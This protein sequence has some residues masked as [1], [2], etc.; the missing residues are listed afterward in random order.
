MI[1][2]EPIK[3][4]PVV[5]NGPLDTP[6]TVNDGLVAV[7]SAVKSPVELIKPE[8]LSAS[9]P[10]RAIVKLVSFFSVYI[11]F[12]VPTRIVPLAGKPAVEPTV[13]VAVPEPTFGDDAVTAAETLV[14]LSLSLKLL[15]TPSVKVTRETAVSSTIALAPEKSVLEMVKYCH[16]L[17]NA[18]S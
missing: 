15:K 12:S 13:K 16:L 4:V 17:P 9:L 18:I 3:R 5:G 2:S 1:C 10:S 6:S 8:V 11:I 14:F 7:I